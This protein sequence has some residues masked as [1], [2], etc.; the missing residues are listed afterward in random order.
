MAAADVDSFRTL[1]EEGK[2]AWPDIELAPDKLAA[3]VT[4]DEV[5]DLRAADL[6]LACACASGDPRAAEI[7]AAEF[8]ADIE[9][10]LARV[11]SP[12][13]GPEDA[14]QMLLH[15]ILVGDEARAPKIESYSGRGSLRNWVRAVAARAAIDLFRR[16]GK[17]EVSAG[18][19]LFESLTDSADPE[20]DYLK[21]NYR[22]EFARAFETAVAAVPPRSRNYLRHAFIE[23]L[24]IDQVAALYGIHRSSAARRLAA[25][26]DALLQATRAA[27]VHHLEVGHTEVDS[28]MRLI[29]S[30]FDVSIERIFGEHTDD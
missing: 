29:G 14:R 19:S 12:G 10:A 2:N 24:S 21:R 18:E 16:A 28:I 9:R 13:A 23:H 17:R 27:L 26:R 11:R 4:S 3:F 6:Y 30:R 20:L 7:F 5:A 1:Y 8:G 15:R 25:A 22:K